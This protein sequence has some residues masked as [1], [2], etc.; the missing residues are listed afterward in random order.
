[1]AGFEPR[2]FTYLVSEVT[3]LAIVQQLLPTSC[4]YK[5]GHSRPLFFFIFVFSIQLIIKVHFKYF[6]DDW[7]RTSDLRTKVTALPT[8][9]QTLLSIIVF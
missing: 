7:I 3:T 6:A 8:E 9:P 5:K 2:S 1:M 4:F